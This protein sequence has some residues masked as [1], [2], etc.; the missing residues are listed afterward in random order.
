MISDWLAPC[1]SLWINCLVWHIKSDHCGHKYQSSLSNC[2]AV[3][4]CSVG[5]KVGRDVHVRLY[6]SAGL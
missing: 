4:F 5:C 1:L 2:T 6:I 3:F